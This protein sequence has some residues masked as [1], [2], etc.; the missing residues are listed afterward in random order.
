MC[1]KHPDLQSFLFLASSSAPSLPAVALIS[2]LCLI[3]VS[4][5]T[6]SV[7]SFLPAYIFALLDGSGELLLTHHVL[8]EC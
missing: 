2:H 7:P 8:A 1:W 3:E 4:G 5:L 6:I